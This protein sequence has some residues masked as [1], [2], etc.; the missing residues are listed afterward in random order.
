MKLNEV[1]IIGFGR[2][3]ALLADI[4]CND[5]QVYYYDIISNI[6]SNNKNITFSPLEKVAKCDLLFFSVPII[7]FEKSIQ[8]IIPY[9][10]DDT[11]VLDV[12]SVKL[13]SYRIMS[14]YLPKHIE[15]LPTHPMFGPDSVKNRYLFS[16]EKITGNNS[17][18]LI[19]FLNKNYGVDWVKEAQ[20]DKIDNGKTIRITGGN[21][22]IS[23]SLNV[24]NTEVN[25]KI[26][27]NRTDKFFVKV[28]NG[29]IN[30][31]GIKGLPFVICPVDETSDVLLNFIREYLKGLGFK[32]IEMSCEEHDR[33][34][35]YSLCTTQLIGR[36]MDGIGIKH[37]DIDT[38]NFKNLVKMKETAI[39][40]SFELFAGLQ[41]YN[42]FAIEMREK[43]KREM[44]NIEMLL[45]DKRKEL[46]MEKG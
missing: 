21:N 9:I 20:I 26:D 39:N 5:F 24:D 34:T 6:Q 27:D 42:P 2:F 17:R 3:G 43:L 38:E 29:E 37:S 44:E 22:S 31:Y 32:V 10:S 7:Y 8:D 30:I 46:T 40:D 28:E 16:W 33:I 15:I 35:A 41:N 4:L 45:E 12:L 13:Y 18:R 14:K 1:G 36:L 19:D 23:L 11:I 25:L